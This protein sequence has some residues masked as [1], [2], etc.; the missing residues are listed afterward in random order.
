VRSDDLAP[1]A[2]AD[3]LVEH[4]NA[5]RPGKLTEAE[6]RYLL[7]QARETLARATGETIEDAGRAMHRACDEGEFDLRCSDQFAMVSVYS[8]ILVIYARVELAGIVH[9]ERN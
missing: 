1:F 7:D 8:R 9:P 5:Q 2:V 6:H 4:M 3:G